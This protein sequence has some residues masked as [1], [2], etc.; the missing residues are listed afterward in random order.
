MVN[1]MKLIGTVLI[2]K[3]FDEDIKQFTKELVRGDF[4]EFFK[5]EGVYL[6]RLTGILENSGNANDE[7]TVTYTVNVRM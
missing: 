3:S 1:Y 5:D 2:N 7:F 4:E 6:D